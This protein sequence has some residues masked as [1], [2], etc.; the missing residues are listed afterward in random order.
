MPDDV[1]RVY[2]SLLNSRGQ[3]KEDPKGQVFALLV[4]VFQL[5]VLYVSPVVRSVSELVISKQTWNREI[6]Y[7]KL[8]SK[9]GKK[10]T[11]DLK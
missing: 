2:H 10:H 6:A 3:N 11:R 7:L 4:I 9:L 5:C 1:C 8:Q